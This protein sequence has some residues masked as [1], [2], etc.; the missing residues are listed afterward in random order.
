MQLARLDL[1]ARHYI[2]MY[3]LLPTTPHHRLRH[4]YPRLIAGTNLPTSKGWI[5]WL[6]KAECTHITFAQDYYTIESK[7]TRRKRTQVYRVQDQLSANEPTAPYIIGRELNLRRL[8]GRQWESN[9]QPSEHLRPM[10]IKTSAS[11]ETA[12][13]AYITAWLYRFT[14][15]FYNHFNLSFS[16]KNSFY[17]ISKC[18][19]VLRKILY[20]LHVLLHLTFFRVTTTTSMIT[21]T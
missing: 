5:A 19:V 3:R 7:D 12:T 13:T 21:T 4:Y 18:C 11:T 10:T 16:A 15:K 9:P 8:P 2:C 20:N 6:V 17:N 1:P 14:V